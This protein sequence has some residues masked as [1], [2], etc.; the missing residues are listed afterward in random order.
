GSNGRADRAQLQAVERGFGGGAILL[1]R[2]LG[3]RRQR[4]KQQ[5][6]QSS[7]E[8]RHGSLSKDET[9]RLML[10]CEVHTGRAFGESRTGQGEV[11]IAGVQSGGK[12][13]VAWGPS[14]RTAACRTPSIP[15]CSSCWCG[16][17][18]ARSG[19]RVVTA[20]VRGQGRAEKGSRTG[21][22][23]LF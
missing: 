18:A 11:T 5:E 8:D 14:D 4:G 9:T 7:T 22:N 10:P 17:S 2:V 21:K 20:A 6:R 1:W 23:R 19:T 15:G 13:P 3:K 12:L 16:S